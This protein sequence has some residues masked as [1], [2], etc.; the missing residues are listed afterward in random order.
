MKIQRIFIKGNIFFYIAFS[1][2]HENLG[3]FYKRE[4]LLNFEQAYEEIE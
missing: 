3:P 2:I 4:K 1:S